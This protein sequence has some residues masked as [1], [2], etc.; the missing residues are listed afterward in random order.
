MLITDAQEEV[1]E[2]YWGGSIGQAVSGFLWLV[3]GG[4]IKSGHSGPSQ[5]RPVI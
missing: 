5:N 1:R 2:I 4:H 3:V